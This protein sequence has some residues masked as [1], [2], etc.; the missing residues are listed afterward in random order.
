VLL[1]PNLLSAHPPE[2][3]ITTDPEVVRTVAR[4]VLEAGGSPFIGDSPGL[5]PFKRLASKT[6]MDEIAQQLGIEIVELSRPTP[7]SLRSDAVFKK[8]EI[9]Y[10]ALNADVVI[11][12]PKL[13]THSQMLLTLGVKNL[14]GTIVAQRKVEW[15][16][17]AGVDRD[18]F[19]SLHLDI[20]LAIKP[21]RSPGC[22]YMLFIRSTV[23]FVSPLQGSSCKRDR[24]DRR[25]SNHLQGRIP[26]GL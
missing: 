5:D 17:M 3:R 16:H 18:T 15:H 10:Q 7:V 20:Y 26:P 13:K 19:G 25:G 12:L 1:K 22:E 21:C 9:A 11:N 24:P 4:M 23:A 2:R 6:G 14:F 8:L